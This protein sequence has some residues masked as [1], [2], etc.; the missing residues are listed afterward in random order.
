MESADLI[1]SN[2]SRPLRCNWGQGECRRPKTPGAPTPTLSP[3]ESRPA[4]LAALC[5]LILCLSRQLE[6]KAERCDEEELKNYCVCEFVCHRGLLC[7]L[8]VGGPHPL[9]WILYYWAPLSVQRT[10][11]HGWIFCCTQGGRIKPFKCRALVK[12]E[13]VSIWD[14]GI[15]GEGGGVRGERDP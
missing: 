10:G 3:P 2:Q 9:L 7:A 1:F 14:Y 4:A 11:T 12:N 6:D 15:W 8:R 5:R 13:M